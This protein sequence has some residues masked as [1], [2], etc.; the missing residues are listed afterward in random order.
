MPRAAPLPA[1]PLRSRRGD[2]KV[3][4]DAEGETNGDAVGDASDWLCSAELSYAVQ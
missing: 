4:P 1:P 3:D 2:G